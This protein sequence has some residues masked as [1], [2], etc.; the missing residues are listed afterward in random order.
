ML[1]VLI[2]NGR[3]VDGTGSPWF[4]AEI[5]TKDGKIVL[6]RHRIREETVRAIDAAGSVVAPGFIDMHTH[7]DLRV[8]APPGADIGRCW[9]PLTAVFSP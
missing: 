8:F 5:G 4:K 6:I 1:D 9:L 3:I 7:S 2:W